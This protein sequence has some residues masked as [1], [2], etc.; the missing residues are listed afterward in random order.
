MQLHPGK[1]ELL[2]EPQLTLGEAVVALVATADGG[3][4]ESDAVHKIRS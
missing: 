4:T 2:T 1:P 3:T